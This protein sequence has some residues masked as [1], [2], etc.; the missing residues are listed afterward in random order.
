MKKIDIKGKNLQR[1]GKYYL[2]D[3][4]FKNYLLADGVKEDHIIKFELD[5]VENEKYRESKTSN[6]TCFSNPESIVLF[7]ITVHLSNP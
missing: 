7:L 4:L 1:S 3:P 6:R 5:R 2:L